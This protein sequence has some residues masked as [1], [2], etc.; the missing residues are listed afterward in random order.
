MS[1]ALELRKRP[2]VGRRS[3]MHAYLEGAAL[4]FDPPPLAVRR[5]SVRQALDQDRQRLA[6]DMHTAVDRVIDSVLA[7]LPTV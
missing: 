3:A 4:V 2:R 7:E 1:M 5:M 6:L